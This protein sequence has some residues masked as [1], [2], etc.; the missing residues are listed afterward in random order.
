MDEKRRRGG[1][2]AIDKVSSLFGGLSTEMRVLTS[3]VG[4]LSDTMQTQH[5]E[6]VE[7]RAQTTGKISSLQ[8]RV[9]DLDEMAS[10]VDRAHMPHFNRVFQ[11]ARK[12]TDQSDYWETWRQQLLG[13]GASKGVWIL[14]IALIVGLLSILGL[15]EWA[16]KI[17][18]IIT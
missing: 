15:P 6:T 10:H 18:G 1:D 4:K 14:F 11:H 9:A 13:D 5:D 17:A 12:D 8:V 2:K 16:K 3:A 7:Y